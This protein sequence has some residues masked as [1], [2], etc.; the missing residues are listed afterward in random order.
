MKK[1]YFVEISE[2]IYSERFNK[3]LSLVSKEKREQIEQFHFDIDKKLSLYSEILTR[4][5]ICKTLNIYNN[6]IIFQKNQYGKP[7]L[8]GHTDF[9]FNV[10]HTRDAVV[11]A[12]SNQL[13]GVDI[14]KIR[15]NNM[16]IAKRF[17]TESEVAYI[18]KTEVDTDKRFY[19]V[20][21]KKEAYIKYLGKGLSIP[22]SS[23]EVLDDIISK[24]ELTLQINDYII[25]VCNERATKKI[26][27]IELLEDDI[28]NKVMNFL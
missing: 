22:I 9:H 14:E 7:Y 1:L 26:D 8:S 17:F 10:S 6:E 20:W 11:I 16:K 18:T 5:I 24:Q 4:I 23:F 19:E 21:T 15:T 3:L 28:E 27:I 25:S 13:V 2:I 12:I